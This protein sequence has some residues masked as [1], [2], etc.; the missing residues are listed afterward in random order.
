MAGKRLA[1]PPLSPGQSQASSFLEATGYG[2]ALPSGSDGCSTGAERLAG[3]TAPELGPVE[4][5]AG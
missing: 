5:A 2:L 1:S 3:A 4:S